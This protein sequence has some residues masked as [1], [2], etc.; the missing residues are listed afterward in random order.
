MP[1]Y[2]VVKQF[3]TGSANQPAWAKNDTYIAQLSGSDDKLW[4]Y[5]NKNI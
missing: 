5:I 1:T 2:R 4:E 3:I